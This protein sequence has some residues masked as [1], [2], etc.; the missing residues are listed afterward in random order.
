[1]VPIQCCFK[2]PTK[3]EVLKSLR[4]KMKSERFFLLHQ[5]SSQN[6]FGADSVTFLKNYEKYGFKIAQIF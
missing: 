5:F 3:N 2:K 1:M 4:K 6:S